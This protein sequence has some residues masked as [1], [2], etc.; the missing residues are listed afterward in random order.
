[1]CFTQL[2]NLAFASGTAPSSDIWR[3]GENCWKAGSEGSEVGPLVP[4]WYNRLVFAPLSPILYYNS[5]SQPELIT[6]SF[7]W[8][9]ISKF[10]KIQNL[11]K[12]LRLLPLIFWKYVF[13][14]LRLLC[15]SLEGRIDLRTDLRR[16]SVHS[17]SPRV[18][19]LSWRDWARGSREDVVSERSCRLSRPR[20]VGATSGVAGSEHGPGP[21]SRRRGGGG[22]DARLG[23][24]VVLGRDW[25]PEER[26][27]IDNKKQQNQRI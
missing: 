22:G 25:R 18:R 14:L 8:N 3:W 27:L 12:Q 20:R 6:V 24:G 4:G 15:I 21:P 9:E 16:L 7:S 11:R 10:K 1:M 26:S 2:N 5:A 19:R 13:R 23:H 17:I